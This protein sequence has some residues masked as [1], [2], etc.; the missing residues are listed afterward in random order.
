MNDFV[1]DVDITEMQG[2]F[3]EHCADLFE[4]QETYELDY[5]KNMNGWF[6]KQT[7]ALNGQYGAHAFLFTDF[8]VF[9]VHGKFKTNPAKQKLDKIR[10]EYFY[11]MTQKF[12]AD[13]VT[14]RMEYFDAKEKERREMAAIEA[15]Y[16]IS[17][18]KIRQELD[19]L[20]KK[21]DVQEHF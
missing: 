13:Y 8:E 19:T 17:R 6:V 18:Q 16:D 20:S 11:M 15:K 21:D 5:S 2:F 12:G 10:M 7:M 1:K 3:C 14:S 9:Y 4:G